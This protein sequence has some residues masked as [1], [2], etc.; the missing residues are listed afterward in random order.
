MGHPGGRDPWPRV[1]GG[2]KLRRAR[3][4]TGRG[5]G[6]CGSLGLGPL[7]QL[8]WWQR[9]D[10][11]QG[12]DDED[13]GQQRGLPAEQPPQSPFRRARG[14]AFQHPGSKPEGVHVA[15][16]ADDGDER[17]L[18]QEDTAIRDAPQLGR[19]AELDP[20]VGDSGGDDNGEGR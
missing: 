13:D 9:E 14:L 6:G 7:Q 2:G 16:R 3:G 10:G 4:A 5:C 20:R 18:D 19:S 15:E 12:S 8:A 17:D 11:E 1:L